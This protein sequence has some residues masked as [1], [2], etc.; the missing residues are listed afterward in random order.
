MSSANPVSKTIV[1]TQPNALPSRTSKIPGPLR[2]PAL[3]TLSLVLSSVLYSIAA[4][5]LFVGDLGSVS[6]RL[7]EWWEVIGLVGWRAVELGIGWWSN[8]DGEILA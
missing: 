8:Y 3:V 4:R 5:Y 6:R 2:F 7:T 1:V